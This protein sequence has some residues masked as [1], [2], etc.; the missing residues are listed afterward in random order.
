ML[1]YVRLEVVRQFRNPQA[2]VVRLAIPAGFYLLGTL[3]SDPGGRSEGLP[4]E[5]A[6]MVDLAVFGAMMSALFATGPP[7]AQERA[8]GWLRQLRVMPLRAGAAVTGKVVA[9]MAF[10]LPSIALVAVAAETSHGLGLGWGRW[11]ALIGLMWVATAPVAGLGVLI[12]F[13]IATA[14]V[15]E[16]VTLLA[17]V[18][19]A[20]LGGLWVSV[21]DLPAALQTIAPAMPTNA[22]AELGR[23]AASGGPIPVGAVSTLLG[24][25]CALTSL[26]A[27]SW[28]PLAGAR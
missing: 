27:L 9:A 3:G 10:A 11:A 8:I 1:G 25:T 16:G 20:V 13:A 4:S 22:I 7:L 5:T 19:M 17:L 14:E 15:A 24:W 18:T 26:A 28:R 12:G 6:S 2:L 23:A 21:D